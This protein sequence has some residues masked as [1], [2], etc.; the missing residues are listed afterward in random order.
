MKPAIGP[1]IVIA[2]LAGSLTVRASG[3]AMSSWIESATEIGFAALSR[4]EKPVKGFLENWLRCDTS[5]EEEEAA[6]GPTYVLVVSDGQITGVDRDGRVTDQGST[7][8]VAGLPV[9]TGL[10]PIP[11]KPGQKP[12]MPQ[13]V[14]GLGILKAFERW[15]SMMES[16]VEINLET[17]EQPMVVLS[18]GLTADLGHGMYLRKIDRLAQVMLQ[19]PRLGIKPTRVDLR[20]GRQVIVECD[21]N[22]PGSDKEA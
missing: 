21:R 13:L 4:V 16:L 1:S 15:P 18:D 2:L 3:D 9:L 5:V 19:A 10:P 14:L 20:F 17:L 8:D 12:S 6:P 11:D 7:C 22:N